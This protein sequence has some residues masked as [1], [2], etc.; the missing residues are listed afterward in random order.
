MKRGHD[1]FS[2][3]HAALH[4]CVIPFNLYTIERARVAADE[5]AARECHLWKRILT[6]F[7][8]SAGT[9]GNPL[10]AFEYLFGLRVRLPP[11]EFLKRA[12]MRIAIVQVSDEAQINLVIFRVVQKG[13]AA[14]V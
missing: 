3:Q 14:R 9:V 13:T 1:A 8:Q 7:C 5:Y 11:L 6:A 4:C 2:S 12:E 10:P